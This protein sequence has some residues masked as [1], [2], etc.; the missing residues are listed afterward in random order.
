M[1]NAPRIETSEI[2]DTDLDNIAGG[3]GVHASVDGLPAADASA[4]TG[5]VSTVT[6]VANSALAAAPHLTLNAGATGGSLHIG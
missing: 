4:L 6:G 1:S 3:I 5:A 2:A